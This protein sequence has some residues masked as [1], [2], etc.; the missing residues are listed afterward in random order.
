MTSTLTTTLDTTA[1]VSSSSQLVAVIDI[2]TSLIRMVIAQIDE[3]GVVS[4]LETLSQAVSLGRDTFTKGSIDAATTEQCVSVL[5]SYREHLC[6]FEITNPEKVRV[7]ATSAVREASN[8]LSFLS[9]LYVATGFRVDPIDE[10]EVNRITYSGVQPLLHTEPRFAK[11]CALITEV[12]GG[13][14]EVLIAQ[15]GDVSFA[16]T[17]RLGSLR[18]RKMLEA[19]RTPAAKVRHIMEDHI[20]KI[21]AQVRQH[22]PVDETPHLIALGGDI[23][24]AATQLQPNWHVDSL[25]QLSTKSVSQLTDET[26]K[27]SAEELVRQH[28]LTFPEA[29][30]LGPALLTYVHLARELQ[31]EHLFVSGANMRDGLLQELAFPDAWSQEFQSQ[32]IRSALDLGRRFRFD[33]AHAQHIARLCADLFHELQDEHQLTPRYELLLH[34]AALLHDI[35]YV[36]GTRS[37]HKH[38]MYLIRNAELFGL[39]QK[40]T[41][42]VAMVARYHRRASP[43]P[44]HEG[45]SE[46]DWEGRVAVAKMAGL[47]RVADALDRS[48]RQRVKALRCERENGRLVVCAESSDDLSMERLALKQKSA[49]FEEVFGLHVVLRD[50]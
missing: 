40:D 7:V 4:R 41:L 26:L 50:V 18:L 46:L 27:L 10:S 32:I 35:G 20:G 13:S 33:E 29:E 30:T 15:A 36:V 47:L 21:V 19:G 2:G 45:Y 48:N 1:G 38:S 22:L 37:H 39:S 28:G 17:Y 11:G 42:L 34:L 25:A 44:L 43:K 16:H 5:K 24:F 12:G 49:L 14:T 8:C 31:L 23:R 3:A 6:E 9:R